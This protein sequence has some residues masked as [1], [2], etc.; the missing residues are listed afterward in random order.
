MFLQREKSSRVRIT[1]SLLI[2]GIIVC[3]MLSKIDDNLAINVV[4]EFLMHFFDE[5]YI[6]VN[7][8]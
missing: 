2:Y 5:I 4:D 8:F 7:C 3:F 6:E 1:T